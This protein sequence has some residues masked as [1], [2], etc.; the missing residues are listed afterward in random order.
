[1]MSVD[2]FVDGGLVAGIHL[3]ELQS[4]T[5]PSVAPHYP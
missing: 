4:Q 5:H 2:I 1:M 3:L